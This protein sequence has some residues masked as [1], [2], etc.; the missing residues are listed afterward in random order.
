MG[1]SPAYATSGFTAMTATGAGLGLT[2]GDV[3]S[4]SDLM[5]LL[6]AVHLRVRAVEEP[7]LFA[8]HGD[9]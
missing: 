7:H 5:A 6:V 4:L 8:L 3:V 2:T 9:T 1:F